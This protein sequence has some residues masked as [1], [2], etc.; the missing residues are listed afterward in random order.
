MGQVRHI[1]TT[2]FYTKRIENGNIFCLQQLCST[3]TWT[4][5]I[6]FKFIDSRYIFII[7]RRI[8]YLLK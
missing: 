4:T 2:R 8:T 5:C 6:R 3:G 1:I 7:I